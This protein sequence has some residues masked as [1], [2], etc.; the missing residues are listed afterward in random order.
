MFQRA[1][2][3]DEVEAPERSG[4]DVFDRSYREAQGFHPLVPR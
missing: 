2:E 4:C 3:N 1:D